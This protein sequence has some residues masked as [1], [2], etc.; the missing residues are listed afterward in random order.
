VV[1][2]LQRRSAP[3]ADYT[4]DP[5]VGEMRPRPVNSSRGKTV[6]LVSMR[7]QGQF[8]AIYENVGIVDRQPRRRCRTHAYRRAYKVEDGNVLNVYS[9]TRGNPIRADL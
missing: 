7:A 2:N 8:A 9:V 5:I 4:H 3:I 1:L 6:S